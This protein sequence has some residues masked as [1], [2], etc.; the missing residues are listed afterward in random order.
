MKDFTV[1][2]VYVKRN[3]IKLCLSYKLAGS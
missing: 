1:V 3:I 2:L